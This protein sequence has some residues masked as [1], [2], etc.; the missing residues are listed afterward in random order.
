MAS[1]KDSALYVLGRTDD[2]TKHY[3]LGARIGQPGQFG[4]AQM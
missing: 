4:Y 2:I 1:A 3:R